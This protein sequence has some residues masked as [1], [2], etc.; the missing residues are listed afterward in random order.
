MASVVNGHYN[1]LLSASS[2]AICDDLPPFVS[3]LED[4]LVDLLVIWVYELPDILFAIDCQSLSSKLKTF[5]V[6][7]GFRDVYKPCKSGVERADLIVLVT[8][9]VHD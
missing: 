5:D 4:C 3:H 7:E 6:R 2:L 1:D 8:S 9:N